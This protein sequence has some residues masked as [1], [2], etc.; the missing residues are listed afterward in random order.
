MQRHSKGMTR[1]NGPEE[2]VGKGERQRIKRKG[3][4]G[5]LQGKGVGA[6]GASGS[7]PKRCAV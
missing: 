2:N 1:I 3:K 5:K 7:G 4:T 6:E